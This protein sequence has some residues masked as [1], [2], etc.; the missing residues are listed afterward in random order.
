[1]PIDAPRTSQ[2]RMGFLAKPA[3]LGAVVLLATANFFAPRA[4]ELRPMQG[5][6]LR[7]GELHG[8]AYY[9]VEGEGYNVVAT[10][11][12]PG[13]TPV[14]FESTLLPGQKIVVS[15]PGSAGA[16]AQAI[17]FWRQDDRLL[18]ETSPV[19]TE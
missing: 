12:S 14:R 15:M 9:T 8:V 18:V 1:M 10:L 2:A 13:G 19:Q 6:S 7:L 5:T 16:K 17:E 11:A 4:A 3:T